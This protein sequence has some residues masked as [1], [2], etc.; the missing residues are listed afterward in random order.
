M[1]LI[2]KSKKRFIKVGWQGCETIESE[3]CEKP[4]CLSNQ[5]CISHLKG[6]F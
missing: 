4:N 1:E 5:N 2:L 3:V 6:G